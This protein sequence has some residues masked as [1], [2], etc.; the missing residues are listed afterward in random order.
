MIRIKVLYPL[1]FFL[2]FLNVN[3]YGLG[4][5][6][7]NKKTGHLELNLIQCTIKSTAH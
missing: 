7:F 5:Y 4:K 3:F 1:E 2:S 6:I